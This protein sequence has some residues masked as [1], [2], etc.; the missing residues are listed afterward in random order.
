[1]AGAGPTAHRGDPSC[2]APSPDP[3]ASLYL[4]VRKTGKAVFYRSGSQS[5]V[6]TRN[7]S[8]HHLGTQRCKFLTPLDFLD[9]K[10]RG[11]A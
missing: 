4:A 9:Q 2:L 7:I 10:L 8:Q 1:M 11:V 5:G 3:Q 6:S